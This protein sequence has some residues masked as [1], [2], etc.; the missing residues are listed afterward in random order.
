MASLDDPDRLWVWDL[1]P[2]VGA[3]T[4]FS[5]INP[6]DCPLGFPEPALE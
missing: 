2:P 6:Q 5:E 4:L 3:V 1:E